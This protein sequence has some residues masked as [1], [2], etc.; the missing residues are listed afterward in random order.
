MT[1]PVTTPAD[2]QS[3]KSVL[4]EKIER[5]DGNKLSLLNRVILQLEAEELA[6]SLDA[7]FDED[8]D[9]GRVSGERIQQVLAQVRAEHPYER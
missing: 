9:A 1:K 4:H 2:G 6:A 7:A 3:L 5:L 8:R